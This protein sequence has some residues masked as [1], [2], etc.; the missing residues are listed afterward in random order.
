MLGLVMVAHTGGYAKESETEGSHQG[1]GSVVH[2]VGDITY[3]KPWTFIN[4]RMV[5][6][7][8]KSQH[9]K[10]VVRGSEVQDQPCL[11][12]VEFVQPSL[13]EILS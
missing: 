2:L 7:T 9:C 8:Y 13:H 6:R 4:P 12:M 1:L 5:P 11:Y 10:V 3:M